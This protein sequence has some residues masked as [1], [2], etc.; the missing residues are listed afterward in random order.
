MR[1]ATR[2]AVAEAIESAL[3]CLGKHSWFVR[4]TLNSRHP[5]VRVKS[6]AVHLL[7]VGQH[8][9]AAAQ[10]AGEA[11]FGGAE[12]IVARY[13][14]HWKSV[15]KTDGP[16]DDCPQGYL[17]CDYD[18]S[19]MHCGMPM[20]YCPS[21]FRLRVEIREF[22]ARNRNDRDIEEVP[23]IDVRAATAVVTHIQGGFQ[24][25]D[26]PPDVQEAARAMISAG[27]L[28]RN[29]FSWSFTGPKRPVDFTSPD[30]EEAVLTMR[31]VT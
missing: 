29:R 8:L 30:G 21:L 25:P 11:D 23:E 7:V 5:F 13:R 15:F 1:P 19:C 10:I 26:A 27:V 17:G 2:T 12:A 18:G 31:P 22:M 4:K 24:Y 16:P 20:L 3:L 28:Q 14:N 6:A 9:A